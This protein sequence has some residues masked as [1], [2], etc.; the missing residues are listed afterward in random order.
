L[1]ALL[2]EIYTWFTEKFDTAELKKAKA[3]LEGL[4]C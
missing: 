4:S 3:L 2:A 1:V